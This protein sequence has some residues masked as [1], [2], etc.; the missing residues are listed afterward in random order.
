M[1]AMRQ[2]FA[3][4]LPAILAVLFFGCSKT[5]TGVQ[6]GAEGVTTYFVVPGPKENMTPWGVEVPFESEEE[7]LSNVRLSKD[8]N[9]LLVYYGW[10]PLDYLAL[11]LRLRGVTGNHVRGRFRDELWSAAQPVRLIRKTGGEE[12]GACSELIERLAIKW[13]RSPDTFYTETGSI[14]VFGK[15][16]ALRGRY[17]YACDGAVSSSR[18]FLSVRSMSHIPRGGILFQRH[19]DYRHFQIIDLSTLEEKYAETFARE[20]NRTA[21]LE[22]WLTGSTYLF[23]YEGAYV[24]EKLPVE[25]QVIH[26]D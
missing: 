14:S 1:I 18:K 15:E 13:P 21:K 11:D 9:Q 22:G 16:L 6:R 2:Y 25:V 5:P 17:A 26:L 7:R 23:I 3:K 4:L 19:P 8:G 10:P 12:I 20:F 24:N